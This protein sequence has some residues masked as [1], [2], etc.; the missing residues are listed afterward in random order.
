MKQRCNDLVSSTKAL[1]EDVAQYMTDVIIARQ[2]AASNFGLTK[3]EVEIMQM[4]AKGL[5]VKEIA[6]KMNISDRTVGNHRAHIFDKLDV[7]NISEMIRKATEY[8]IL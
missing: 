3:R 6:S 8:G 5:T 2:S 1:T 4:S 7:S